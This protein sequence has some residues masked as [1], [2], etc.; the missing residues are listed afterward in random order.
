MSAPRSPALIPKPRDWGTH[1]SIA[2]FYFLSLAANYEPERE[3][4]EFLE[5]GPPP[6]YIG[7]GSIVVDDPNAMTKL[8][9][10]AV[11]ESGQRA[12]VSKGWGGL[13]TDALGKASNVFMLG[14]VPHDW[15]F[16][17]V[18]CV[19]HHG[20]AG[21]SA[22]GIALGK[23]TVIVP[24]FGDQPFWGAMIA[25]A[26]AGPQPIPNNTLTPENLASAIKEALKPSTLERAKELGARIASEEGSEAG[27][28][29]FHSTLDFEALRCSLSPSRIAVW[30]VKKTDIIL[31]GFAA[32]T[33][34]NEGLLAFSDLKLYVPVAS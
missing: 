18:S 31:S 30:R 2:G 22:A 1:I 3:L 29:A 6:I 12:L 17:H 32:T 8:I 14:N 19:V 26:G 9:F 11:E 27:A 20:G 28:K 25:K 10:K 4:L 24:F 5:A 16:K 33:L 23:P 15:L 21:T 13:G 7:F 34:G